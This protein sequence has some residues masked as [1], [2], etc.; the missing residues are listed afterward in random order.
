MKL[1]LCLVACDLN[2]N[3]TQFFD[4][5][6]Y[7]WSKFVG[8]QTKF[9]LISSSIPE[10][11]E[12]FKDDIILFD[13]IDG[14]PTA[15]QAQC[16][17]LLYPALLTEIKDAVIISDMDLIPLNRSFYIDSIEDIDD[18]SFVVYRNVI[19]SHSQYPIC[20]CAAN[21]KIWRDI[22]NIR[23]EVD[24]K[25]LIK[26]WYLTFVQAGH[27]YQ[28]SSPFSVIWACDQI[29]LFQFVNNWNDS[30]GSLVCL[31]DDKTGHKRLDRHDIVKIEKNVDEFK[32]KIKFGVYSDFHLP[33]L[34]CY[35]NLIRE[36]IFYE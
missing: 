29:K 18:D 31:S 5:V 4:I 16:I 34:K 10:E 17:R 14:I 24:M 1:E 25:N 22:F 30:S 11:L 27:F 33:R 15:F 36:L 28:I 7:S 23:S 9:I 2:E 6:K 35:Q 21:P 3:Y 12:S 32:I 26:N 13:P 8:I 20:F 19:S